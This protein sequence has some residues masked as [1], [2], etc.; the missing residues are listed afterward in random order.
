MLT[1]KRV[2][3]EITRN[4]RFFKLISERCYYKALKLLDSMPKQNL[5]PILMTILKSTN[6]LQQQT[7][8]QM[9]NASSLVNAPARQA[10][11]PQMDSTTSQLVNASARPAKVHVI[12]TERQPSTR[13]K[14]KHVCFD[15]KLNHN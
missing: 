3:H 2:D 15:A 6:T 11:V 8:Q 4:S 5:D 10:R 7:P 9:E 12:P 1:A 14:T 13:L